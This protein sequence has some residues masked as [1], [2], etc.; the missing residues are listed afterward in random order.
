MP[1]LRVENLTTCFPPRK[2]FFHRSAPRVTAVDDVS[3]EIEEGT[4]V[5]LIGDRGCGKTALALTLAK[6]IP[7]SS[8]R[9]LYD[10]AGRDILKLSQKAFRPLRREIQIL[11]QDS[12]AS[13][14]PFATIDA[15]LEEA[16]DL[17]AGE[18]SPKRKQEFREVL[19]ERMS[20]PPDIGRLL[21]RELAHGQ[22]ERVALARALVPRPRLLLV[23][24]TLHGLD[25]RKQRQLVDLLVSLRAE[26][27]FSL[28]FACHDFHFLMHMADHVLVMSR[29][30]ILE[31]A[32]LD[33]I[34]SDPQHEFTKKLLAST[35]TLTRPP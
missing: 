11:F 9:V 35:M 8:G 20:L 4:T 15:V 18:S 17:S 24:D 23:D 30:R 27:G 34:V 19:L 22:A 3:F 2:P 13:L 14:N 26:L 28:L 12:L 29:G 5:G 7:A 21:P 33:Q 25:L 1:L 16:I 32:P 10:D 31:S 6:L